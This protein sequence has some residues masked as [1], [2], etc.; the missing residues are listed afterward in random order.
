VEIVRRTGWIAAL[1][2]AVGLIPGRS[3]ADPPG[4]T[5]DPAQASEQRATYEDLSNGDFTAAVS[6]VF[7]DS[8]GAR[9]LAIAEAIYPPRRQ[10]VRMAVEN[11]Y[12][13]GPDTAGVPLWWAN[14]VGQARIPYAITAGAVEYFEN[15]IDLYRKGAFQEAGTEPLFS[16]RLLYRANATLRDTVTVGRTL[17]R[18]VYVTHQELVWTY[19]DGAFDPLVVGRRVVVLTRE[20]NVLEIEGDGATRESVAIS[21]HRGIGRSERKIH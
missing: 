2:L 18:G 9:L 7:T 19:D 6:R 14:G 4:Y 13:M 8:T 1:A 5:R 17:F 20:G 3:G 10:L 12:E 16:A 11:R 21:K 15:L